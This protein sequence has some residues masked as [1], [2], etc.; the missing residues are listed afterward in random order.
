VICCRLRAC[1][2]LFTSPRGARSD[3]TWRRD[4]H[5]N[6]PQKTSTF[7]GSTRNH[8]TKRSHGAVRHL[9]RC[10]SKRN[11]HLGRRIRI[12]RHLARW[13]D[14]V[15]VDCGLCSVVAMAPSVVEYFEIPRDSAS[16]ARPNA[17]L[18]QSERSAFQPE[19]SY[20][21]FCETYAPSTQV[22]FGH[23]TRAIFRKQ[24]RIAG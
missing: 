23:V 15:F 17:S 24:R 5:E 18:E 6:R 22:Q 16:N 10:G 21:G 19:S 11:A 13:R 12:V 4:R 2:E 8:R 9:S 7:S 3:E 1:V 14:E 20:L